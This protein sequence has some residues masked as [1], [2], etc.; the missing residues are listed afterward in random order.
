MG[1][2]IN[3]LPPW[4]QRQAIDQMLAQ[5]RRKKAREAQE[6]RKCAAEGRYTPEKQEAAEGGSHGLQG[7]MRSVI[8]LPPVTKKNS[9]RIVKMGQRYAI[10]PSRKYEEYER[11]CEAQLCGARD[12]MINRPVE[13][14]CVFYMQTKRRVDL[15]NLLEAA[16][17]VLTHY[18]VLAD[19]NS[20]IIVSHDGSRVR[21]DKDNPRTEITI[22]EHRGD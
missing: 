15:T 19:D 17:D 18:G 12:M 20:T 13:V 9:Q 16:D 10:K 7:T 8:S 3:D 5:T 21:Y 22:T 11:A 2:N 6:A 1:I 14:K 4:A